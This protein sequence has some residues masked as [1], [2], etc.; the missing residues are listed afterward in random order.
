VGGHDGCVAGEAHAHVLVPQRFDAVAFRLQS[1]QHV[2][3]AQLGPAGVNRK[4]K[5]VASSRVITC[6]SPLAAAAAI[7][8]SSSRISFSAALIDV[9]PFV[10]GWDG[11]NGDAESGPPAAIAAGRATQ[12][13]LRF[14]ISSLVTDYLLRGGRARNS[15][16]ILLRWKP[17]VNLGRPAGGRNNQNRS[18]SV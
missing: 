7:A 1:R 14:I 5:D 6:A 11:G 8:C 12:S 2:A 3:G 13:R 15:R 16:S 9:V 18:R 4:K 17:E 10:D